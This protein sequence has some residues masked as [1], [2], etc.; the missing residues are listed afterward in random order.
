MLYIV[1]GPAVAANDI[2][3]LLINYINYTK[4][5]II[6]VHHTISDLVINSI[7]ARSACGGL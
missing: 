5:G 1:P 7:G 3:P 2:V 6:G 4:Q